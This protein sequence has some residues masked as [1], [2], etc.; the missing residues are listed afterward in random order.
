M[1][2]LATQTDFTEAGELMLFIDESQVTYL[3]DTMWDKGYLDT[4]QMSGA[5]Q[6]L[7]SNDLIWSRYIHSYLMG[8]R[9]PMWDLMAWNADATLMP[10]RMHSEFL[11][12]LFLDDDL[13]EGRYNVKGR[14]VFLGDIQVPVFM[15]ETLR[16]HVAPWR[17]VFKFNFLCN[18]E[19]ITFV[20]CSSGHNAGIISEPGHPNRYFRISTRKAGAKHIDANSWL[21]ATPEQNGSWWLALEQ[22]LAERSTTR[23]APPSMNGDL[24][25]NSQVRLDVHQQLSSRFGFMKNRC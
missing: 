14:S 4:R 21:E 25:M 13:A 15:V 5:F 12:S 16:D 19:E 9:L 18:T 1:T 3:E 6:L 22:W 24:T 17:S 7:R 2:L 10:Y 23:V 20:L 11:R 8:E